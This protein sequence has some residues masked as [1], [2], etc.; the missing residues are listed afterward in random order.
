MIVDVLHRIANHCQSLSRDEAIGK[1]AE[2]SPLLDTVRN[3]APLLARLA[4]L[5]AF[6]AVGFYVMFVYIVSWLQLADGIAPS[7]ALERPL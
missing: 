3:H 5:S 6:N 1:K 2:H 4:A 7:R